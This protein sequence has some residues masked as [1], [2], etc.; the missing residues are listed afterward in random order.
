MADSKLLD[1]CAGVRQYRTTP[2]MWVRGRL[3]VVVVQFEKHFP[4][5][6]KT[7]IDFEAFAAALKPRPF[8]TNSG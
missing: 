7:A 8:K 2:E 6:L 1:I 4:H 5:W 3:H